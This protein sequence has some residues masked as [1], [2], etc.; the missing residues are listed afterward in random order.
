MKCPR[1]WA[2]KAYRHEFRGWWEVALGCLAFRPMKCSHCYHRYMVHW[3]FTI[4]K[5]VVIAP[6]S[7][8]Q[9]SRWSY[10]WRIERAHYAEAT[11]PNPI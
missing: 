1:C 4:G 6:R 11:T 3:V 2:D 8:N 7:C 9:I 5:S 10:A